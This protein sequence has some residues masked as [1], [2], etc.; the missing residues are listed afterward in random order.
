MDLE[1][2]L[3]R[4][5][6]RIKDDPWRS[7]ATP[8]YQTAIFE[9]QRP[10]A[11]GADAYHYT[12]MG[13]PTR[14]ALEDALTE[15]EGG[16]AAFAFTSGMAAIAASLH[17]YQ[18]G[19]HI[20]ATAGLYGHTFTL[21]TS[22][23]QSAGITCSF[24]DTASVEAVKAAWTDRTAGLLVEMPSNP[25]L[26]A[27]DLPALAALCRERKAKL[28]VDSTFLTPWGI[29]PLELGADIVIHSA[30]KY[31]AGHND[32]LAGA[33]VVKAPALAADLAFVQ[34]MTGAVLSPQDAWLTL[35]GMK[36]L[37]LRMERCQ[38]N[39]MRIAEWLA[40]HPKVA[41]V[42]YPGLSWHPSHDL[43]KAQASGFG[44]VISFAMR[45][46]DAARTTLNGT[47]LIL[48]AESLGGTETLITYP[49]TQTHPGLPAE[50]RIRHGIDERL[51]RLSVG[52]ESSRDLIKDLEQAMEGA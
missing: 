31:L 39:A 28:M 51:L 38:E 20:L 1:T 40:D 27:A 7:V 48:L 5:G 6:S 2:R 10:L 44:G 26:K 13:N 24:V 42:H 16:A 47:R 8:I 52:I 11:E 22:L 9:H 14:T 37:A 41:A 46:P 19:D 15:L 32:T 36:T 49:W 18:P 50:E 12:R 23:F 3:A 43:M 17:L 45:D 21:M 34:V 30:T 25:L 4:A 29:R 33:V 35:R